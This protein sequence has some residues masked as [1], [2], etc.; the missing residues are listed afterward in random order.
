MIELYFLYRGVMKFLDWLQRDP[1]LAKR[2]QQEWIRQQS[3]LHPAERGEH[4][5]S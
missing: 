4:W 2:M 5:R 3:Q 1:Q